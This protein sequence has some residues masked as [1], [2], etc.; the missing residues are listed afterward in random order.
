D[1]DFRAA[2]AVRV[3]RRSSAAVPSRLVA[4]VCVALALGGCAAGLAAP[5]GQRPA[6]T[7]A[8]SRA[9]LA[10]P[11]KPDCAFHAVGLG[12]TVPD[13]AEAARQKL[14]DERRCY[15]RAEMQVRTRL[16]RLQAAVAAGAQPIGRKRCGLFC[17]LCE[18][19]VA[20]RP[21]AD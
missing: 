13:A 12:D 21:A 7:P 15:R 8:S 16:R 5:A 1:H 19:P 10:A 2:V 4:V 11:A 14:D 3:K 9:L 6:I 17:G 18:A 20:N